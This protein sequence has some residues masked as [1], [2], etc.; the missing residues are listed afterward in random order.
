MKRLAL[1]AIRFY[2]STVSP[3]RPPACRFE[4][5]CSN[6]AHEAIS[7]HGLLRGGRLTLL[8]LARCHPFSKGGYDPV[9]GTGAGVSRE[10]PAVNS[11]QG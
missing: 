7:R 11:G 8:R 1:A 3:S 5:S 10:T 9:P 4:P 6:Y 2:Q